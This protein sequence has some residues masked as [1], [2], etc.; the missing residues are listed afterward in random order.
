MS[1]VEIKTSYIS[2][3]LKNVFNSQKYDLNQRFFKINNLLQQ[4]KHI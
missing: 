4:N 1:T 2:W 3:S